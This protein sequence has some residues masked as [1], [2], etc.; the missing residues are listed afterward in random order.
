MA[1]KKPLSPAQARE[2][3]A[4]I[5]AIVLGIVFLGVA[6]VQGPKLMKQLSGKPADVVPAVAETPASSGGAPS[7]AS[8]GIATGQLARFGRF[9]LKDPFHALVKNAAPGATG[10]SGPAGAGQVSVVPGAKP[11]AS[12]ATFSQ[13]PGATAPGGPVVPAALILYNGKKQVVVIGGTFPAKAPV[14]RL[15]SLSLKTVRIGLVGGSFANG[16][17]TLP[18]PRGRKIKL[19][20]SSTGATF[21]LQLVKLTTAVKPKAAAPPAVGGVGGA[22]TTPDSTSGTPTTST[23]T[24]TTAG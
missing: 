6:A 23:P 5:A 16:K 15:V 21:V 7:L 8:S 1:P 3:R 13:T 17:T 19:S 24:T 4:K 10:A 12:T 18:L 9:A 11:P 2:R 14:F 22:S 20:N